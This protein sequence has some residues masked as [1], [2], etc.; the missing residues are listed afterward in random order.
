MTWCDPSRPRHIAQDIR[1]GA[2]PVQV[3]GTGFLDFLVALKEDTDGALRPRSLLRG[4]ARAGAADGDR[5]H[6]AGEQ[7]DV[8]HRQNDE[9]ILGQGLRLALV[10]RARGFRLQRHRVRVTV[11]LD[12]VVVGLDFGIHV[13][14]SRLFT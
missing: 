6:D 8:A 12:L 9:R 2:D 1:G 11:R 14:L 13:R 7:D 10:L 5:E 4:C 3:V